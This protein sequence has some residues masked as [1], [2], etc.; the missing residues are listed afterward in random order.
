MRLMSG[1]KLSAPLS[2]LGELVQNNRRIGFCLSQDKE[3]NGVWAAVA[4]YEW[5]ETSGW[6][7]RILWPHLA[8]RPRLRSNLSSSSATAAFVLSATDEIGTA[9]GRRRSLWLVV[10][11]SCPGVN[12]GAFRTGPLS[13]QYWSDACSVLDHCAKEVLNN[14]NHNN[15]KHR[16]PHAF[17]IN[18]VE[19]SHTLSRN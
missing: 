6:C 9:N 8:W 13:N 14:N 3:L 7:Y 18:A 15:K 10:W 4:R 2:R 16:S 1:N 11:T 5:C 12:R 19:R 17:C